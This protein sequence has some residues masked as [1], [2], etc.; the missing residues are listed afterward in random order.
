MGL[1]R[2][3]RWLTGKEF[4][5]CNLYVVFFVAEWETFLEGRV[6]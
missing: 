2:Q 5:L 3:G 6:M 4:D 1:V